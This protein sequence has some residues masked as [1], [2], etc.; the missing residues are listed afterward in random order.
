MLEQTRRDRDVAS[1]RARLGHRFDQLSQQGR[2]M[3]RAQTLDF[4]LGRRP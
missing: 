2:T 1:L 3:T 4:A